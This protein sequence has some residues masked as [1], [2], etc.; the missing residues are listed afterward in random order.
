MLA[1]DYS[2]KILNKSCLGLVPV[3]LQPF[4]LQQLQPLLVV[5]LVGLALHLLRSQVLLAL[6][7]LQHRLSLLEAGLLILLIGDVALAEVSAQPL[8][9]LEDVLPCV[10]CH[11]GD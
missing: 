7:L 3:V 8:C 5:L 4:L 11:F 1:Y 10:C 6:G 2:W 9:H